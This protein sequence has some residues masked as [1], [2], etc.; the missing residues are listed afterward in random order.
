MSKLIKMS[1]L[2]GR[3]DKAILIKEKLPFLKGYYN[4]KIRINKYEIN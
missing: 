3:M 2:Y 4:E 1:N